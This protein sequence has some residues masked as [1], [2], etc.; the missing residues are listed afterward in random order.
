MHKKLLNEARFDL[1]ISVEGPLLVKSGT[2]TW[3]PSVP[4]MQF[5]RTR[6]A[7][8]GETVFIPGSSLKGTLRSYSEKIART[9]NVTCCNPFSAPKE[10]KDNSEGFCGKKLEAEARERNQR[11]GLSSGEIYSRS[12]AAC[13]IF[14]S[15]VMAGRALFADCYPVADLSERLTRRTGVAIDRIL[16]SASG[17]ALFEVEALMSGDFETAVTLR[18]FELWQ[19]GL[20]GLSIRDFCLGRVRVGFGK[21]RGFGAV[22]AK[23]KRLELRSILADGLRKEDGHLLINGIGALLGDARGGYGIE[24]GEAEALRITTNAVL[25]DE[26]IGSSVV[27]DLQPG[28]QGWCAPEAEAIFSECVRS[29]WKRYAASH[30][31]QGGHNGR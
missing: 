2:E 14:G 21:S 7:S 31:A 27:F 11:E 24:E 6:H 10:G 18:N 22:S 8:L 16:G 25:T 17:G 29:N 28:V 23:L 4:D 19:L 26:L 20:L 1:T 13:R 5:V 30:S 9:L 12:C 3:D 15:T